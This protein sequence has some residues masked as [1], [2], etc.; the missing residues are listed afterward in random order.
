MLI[1]DNIDKFDSV[2]EK[3]LYLKFKN[4]IS[5][6]NFY[7]L[8][9][10]FTNYHIKNISGELDFLVLAP[11]HG[12]FAIEVKHGKVWRTGGKW[13]F[14]NKKR[15]VTEKFKSPFAQVDGTM[16]S[17]RNF[18]LK[19]LEKNE[20]AHAH[21]SKILFGTGIA[22][23]GM[24][25]FI[26][27]GTEG[28]PWQVFTRSSLN[29]PISYFIDSLS[30]G[31][32]NVNKDKYFYN[33]NLSRPSNEDCKMIVK[34]L[35][36]DFDID[37]SDVNKI[38]DNDQLIEEYTKEQFSLL[39][40]VNYNSRCLVQGGAGTGKTL[41]A[42]ELVRRNIVA[43]KK[44][45]FF[46]FNRKLGDKL[47]VSVN[48]IKGF[49]SL[50]AYVGTLH[51]FLSLGTDL[52]I[53]EGEKEIT[54][55]FTDILPLDFLLR[56]EAVDESNK[57]DILII[58]EAQ[59]LI[60]SNYLEVF[61]SLLKGGISRGSW[62]FFGDFS[63]QAIYLNQPIEALDLLGSTTNFIK[64]PPLNINCRNTK[65]IAIQNTLLTG[66]E[67][68]EFN[69]HSFE[70]EEIVNKFPTKN[71]RS[72][73][74]EEIIEDFIKRKIPLQKITLLSPKRLESGFMASSEKLNSWIEQG[75]TFSTVQSFKGLENTFIILFDFD[76]L[77]TDES[78]RLL[79][80]GISRAKQKL[81]IV[82]NNELQEEY[83]KLIAS[84]VNKLGTSWI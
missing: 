16:N 61:D 40:F 49:N 23:T 57:F 24:N 35:R 73:C 52:D 19:K 26:D 8:H 17:V 80:I 21:F 18:I 27:F 63:N 72:E 38:N 60:S 56:N 77:V 66:T 45:A 47:N 81:Y 36:G 25:D 5:S 39:D 13:H 14:E 79:Y 22:F 78:Q 12:F 30:K 29:I 53:P 82:L 64:F 3:L 1:P 20:K 75:L 4:D 59:D 70:G 68:P 11:G 32:H 71:K 9:S 46:C 6:A 31:W 51:S 65:K 67:K 62:I 10:L 76:Q 69:K 55:F 33:V 74:V 58:D 50:G 54:N 28:H 7:V 37:Y 42:L 41:M 44:V 43:G 2:G 83:Q 34:L 84:N 15:E 48:E